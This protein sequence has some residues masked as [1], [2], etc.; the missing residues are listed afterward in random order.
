MKKQTSA[1]AETQHK[2]RQLIDFSGKTIYVGVDTHKK[3]WQVA[4]IYDG[5]CLGNHRMA[6][7]ST[8]LIKHLV[9][10]YPG[11]HF[12]CVYES[13]AWGFRLRRELNG[14]GMDCIV[15]HA[16]DVSSSDKEK[17]RKTDN[18]D[19]LKLARTHSKHELNGIHVPEEI[20]QK[21]RSLVRYRIQLVGDITRSKNRLKSL[22]KYQGID[23]PQQFDKKGNW[24]R[25]FMNWIVQQANK[26]ALL[27][28]SL[29]LMLEQI[30]LLRQLLL[31]TEKA[32]REMMKTPKYQQEYQLLLSNPGIGSVVATQWLLEIG[33]VRRF[34]SFDQLNSFI[35]FCPDTDSSG[36]TQRDRG[37]TSR[38]HKRLRS[39]LIEASWQALRTDPALME[40]YRQLLKRMDGKHAII[41]IAHKLVRRIR[42]VLL[43]GVPYQKGIVC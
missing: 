29:L 9:D 35:G 13:G 8:V 23:I 28:D 19:A 26:D 6:A 40:S 27:K 37:I 22:L 21:Q 25:N 15:V 10:R 12:D 14:A 5:I 31:K 33:D 39:V 43:T 42:T 41:R 11:A 7:S 36:D 20:L 24:S 30:S 18:V 17:K 34:G 1:A 16:A 38:G 3:D 4:K 32:L 2:G